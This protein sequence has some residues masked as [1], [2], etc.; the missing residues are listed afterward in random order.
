[1]LK[2][3]SALP[4]PRTV[5][6]ENLAQMEKAEAMFQ[7]YSYPFLSAR[8][9]CFFSFGPISTSSIDEGGDD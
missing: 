4:L 9:C 5:F 6:I 8:D 2:I 7:I 3:E 1:M